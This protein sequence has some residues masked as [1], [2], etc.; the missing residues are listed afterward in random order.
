MP[1]FFIG[2]GGGDV[3]L[4][5]VDG[6]GERRGRRRREPL[7]R[8]G[9]GAGAVRQLGIVAAARRSPTPSGGCSGPRSDSSGGRVRRYAVDVR[10]EGST[11]VV[12]GRVAG[13]RARRRRA[14]RARGGRVG[15]VA[16]TREDLDE[17]Q[18]AI[19]GASAVAAADVAD[20]GQVVAAMAAI[21]ASLGPIDILVANAGIGAYGAFADASVEDIE[22]L[23]QV[24]VLGTVY[25]I[26]AVLPGMIERRRGTWR[27]CRRW[28][29][30]SD[31]RSR[32]RTQRPSSPRSAWPRRSRSSC[33]RTASGCR[34]STRASSIRRS[35][36]RA[37]AVCPRLPKKISA[38]DVAE[39]GHPCRR[40]QPA[41]D[42]R[43][44]ALRGRR[45]HPAPGPAPV[46]VG[47]AAQLPLRAGG[48]AVSPVPVPD[49]D[50]LV[51][52][53]PQ[54]RGGGRRRD[55]R[56]TISARTSSCGGGRAGRPPCFD[57]YC[58]HLG[59]HLGVGKGPLD[60]RQSRA[61]GHR[62]RL[63]PVPVPRMEVRRPTGPVSTFPTAR[64]RSRP[65]RGC[66]A[67]PCSRSTG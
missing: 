37:D 51:P 24:N 23:V 41:G 20:R 52:G 67:G 64:R 57:A 50:R 14:G 28:R 2:R 54:L 1:W 33:R 60:S 63:H 43:A 45:G 36:R 17:V 42:V 65:R 22:R 30:V 58:A 61:A 48:Q 35:S 47:D 18:R 21:E 12:T 66:A 46:R 9:S 6:D 62:R 39:R 34:S 26:K 32:R 10:W 49:P 11:V 55:G 59:A 16:R 4:G 53:G 31:R 27:S 5:R 7:E 56:C 15:L 8:A 38:G 29:D 40:D 19:G 25:P 3:G 13:D 44:P